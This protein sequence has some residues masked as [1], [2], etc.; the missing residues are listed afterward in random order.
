MRPADA[1]LDARLDTSL[2]APLVARSIEVILAGQTDEGAYLAAPRFPTYRYC[3]FRDGSFIADAMDLWGRSDS[4]ARFHR[5]VVGVLQR[6]LEAVA[7]DPTHVLH[8]RYQPDGTPGQEDWPN[9]QLDGFGT[10]L[11]AYQR[12]LRLTEARAD[13]A[14]LVVVRGLADYL[15]RMWPRPNFDCWE[16]FQERVHPSTLAALFAGLRAASVLLDDRYYLGVAEAI[17]QF[18]RSHGVHRPTGA[19]PYLTKHVGSADV[20]AN[21]LWVSLPYGVVAPDSELA[22]ATLAKVHTDLLDPDGG[23]HRYRGDTFYGGGSWILLT[24]DLAQAHLALGERGEAERLRGWIEAQATPEGHLPEQVDT[25][26]LAPGLKAEWDERWGT[27]AT[28][29]LWSHAAYLRLVAAL[30]GR[31]GAAAG[32]GEVLDEGGAAD[33]TRVT[34]RSEARD[35]GVA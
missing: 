24:A 11:W 22:L 26:L 32:R 18:V 7:A 29:L 5:W 10:W 21:L 35:R 34:D 20:D 27:S 1:P 12:H 16:E 28:P 2:D 31:E 14:D 13:A 25:H 9:F 6:Q 23:V 33:G 19:P 30:E 15:T 3:W 8:T 4:A 17:R